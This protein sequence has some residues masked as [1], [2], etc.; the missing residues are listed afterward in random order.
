MM[1]IFL[2]FKIYNIPNNGILCGS[3]KIQATKAIFAVIKK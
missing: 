1:N 3:I 2:D